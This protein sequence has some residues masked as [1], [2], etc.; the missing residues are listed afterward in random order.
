MRLQV[1]ALT[2]GKQRSGHL[3]RDRTELLTPNSCCSADCTPLFPGGLRKA[4]MLMLHAWIW[5]K[6]CREF[7][8]RA[9]E[10]KM[11]PKWGTAVRMQEPQWSQLLTDRGSLHPTLSL[12]RMH[13]HRAIHVL[14]VCSPRAGYSSAVGLSSSRFTKDCTAVCHA[15]GKEKGKMESSHTVLKHLQQW[16]QSNQRVGSQNSFLLNI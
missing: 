4:V 9:V 6:S 13:P 3:P 7:F 2:L 12:A 8:P 15:E 16:G 5:A 10:S 11:V 1:Q 14:W